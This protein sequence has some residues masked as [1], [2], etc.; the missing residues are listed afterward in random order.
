MAIC[1]F[2]GGT[3]FTEALPRGA[4]KEINA[5]R[6]QRAASGIFLVGPNEQL[7]AAIARRVGHARDG[8]AE[9]A[10][11]LF[12]ERAEREYP[13]AG[14]AAE[15]ISPPGVGGAEAGVFLISA[16]EEIAAPIA[17][18]VLDSGDGHSKSAFVFL[19]RGAQAIEHGSRGAAEY[20]SASGAG[21]TSAGR[22]IGSAHNNVAASVS[23][24][25]RKARYRPLAEGSIGN[26]VG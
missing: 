11:K 18:E 25:V 13:G 7:S 20:V 5:S 23:V 2:V 10:F 24:R 17:I 6:A 9:V 15:D 21:R 4:I 16:H 26:F 14:G 22:F 1:I 3:E 19:I 8:K 12:V